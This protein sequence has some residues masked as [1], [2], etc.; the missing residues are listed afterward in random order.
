VIAPL[1]LAA[2]EVKE[3]NPLIPEVGEIVIGLIAFGVL[4]FV[5]MKTA[6]PAAEKAY[7]ERREAIEGGMERAAQAQQEAQ[8][9]LEQYRAQLAEAR[10]EAGRIREQANA[11]AGAIRREMEQKI[12]AEREERS[13]AF[14]EQLAQQRAQAV[15]Q[16]RLEVG[17]IAMELA[18][19]IVGHE[20]SN[21]QRQ[22][23]LIDDFIAGLEA[24]PADSTVSAV[25]SPVVGS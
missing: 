2:G 10:Q 25:S 21:D 3:H 19:R 15:S 14:A 24:S 13:R 1:V 22:R 12:A 4:C 7:R 16:L 5:L 18:E 23:E 11:D 17:S 9:A 6:F 8:Q 20:L